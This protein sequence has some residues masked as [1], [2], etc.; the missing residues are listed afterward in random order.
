MDVASEF[1]RYNTASARTHVTRLAVYPQIIIQ[2]IVYF[3]IGH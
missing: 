1:G 2:S 3:T